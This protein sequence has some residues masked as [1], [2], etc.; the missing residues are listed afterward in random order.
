MV[1]GMLLTNGV[2][3]GPIRGRRCC[4]PNF[5]GEEVIFTVD[6][7][8]VLSNEDGLGLSWENIFTDSKNPK[9]RSV[10]KRVKGEVGLLLWHALE[11]KITNYRSVLPILREHQDVRGLYAGMWGFRRLTPKQSGSRQSSP[12]ESL[13]SATPTSPKRP[14]RPPWK[15]TTVQSKTESLVRSSTDTRRRG[16][17]VHLW[18][19]KMYA[20]MQGLIS[21]RVI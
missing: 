4:C 17:F 16:K 9:T 5:T 18:R 1:F 6:T 7:E 13:D 8:S 19:I 10:V 2:S 14:S 15:P 21:I 11:D 20:L 12:S 3:P